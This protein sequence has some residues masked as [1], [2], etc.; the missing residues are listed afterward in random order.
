MG[1]YRLFYTKWLYPT[2]PSELCFKV[3]VF[4]PQ[5]RFWSYRP[6][7][8]DGF[9][10]YNVAFTQQL[11]P[12]RCINLL[13]NIICLTCHERSGNNPAISYTNRI[14]FMW[15]NAFYLIAQGKAVAHR[16]NLVSHREIPH[17]LY[18]CANSKLCLNSKVGTSEEIVYKDFL[19][20]SGYRWPRWWIV[21]C[22]VTSHCPNQWWPVVNR[23]LKF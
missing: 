20:V 16:I 6:H 12:H 11:K 18:H 17:V 15:K 2:I 19:H 9:V 4:I 7:I 22:P 5:N 3:H 23:I 14:T 8:V 13:T 21:T 10:L 1:N